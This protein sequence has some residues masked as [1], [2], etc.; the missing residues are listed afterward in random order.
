MDDPYIKNY[1]SHFILKGGMLV[2]SIIYIDMRAMI[3][4][5]A[6]MAE[7]WGQYKKRNYFVSDLEWRE[8]ING[9]LDLIYVYM[10]E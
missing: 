5:D 10:E 7:M 1:R 8:V 4:K 9:V 2:A 3:E 6:E